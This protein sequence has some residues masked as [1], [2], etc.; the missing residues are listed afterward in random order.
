MECTVV[1]R[2][3]IQNAAQQKGAGAAAGTFWYRRF[4]ASQR[5]S[6]PRIASSRDD[7]SESNGY[8]QKNK[9]F[10]HGNLLSGRRIRRRSNCRLRLKTCSMILP[11]RYSRSHSPR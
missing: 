11:K 3:P 9:Y 2:T 10:A 7:Q 8:Q 4:L 1:G 5:N 6:C